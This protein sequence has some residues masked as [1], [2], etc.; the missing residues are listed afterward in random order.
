[1]PYYIIIR[2]TAGVGKSTI[3]K[4]LAKEIGA[5][6]FH[7]DEIMKDLNLD[8]IEGEKWIP[9]WKFLKADKAIINNLNKELSSNSII[10]DGNFYFN[11]HIKDLVNKL[12]AKGFIFTLKADLKEC[13][14]RDKTRKNCLGEKAVSDVFKFTG[15]ISHGII[16]NTKDKTPKQIL[17]IIKKRIK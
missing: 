10:I 17:K 6:V 7:F 14:K 8:Y 13:I 11:T 16:I 5:K 3:S 9:L 2:G 1:M 12:N 15:K 4:M